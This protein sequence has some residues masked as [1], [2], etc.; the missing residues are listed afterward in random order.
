MRTKRKTA[1]GRAVSWIA[2]G[3]AVLTVFGAFA[4]LIPRRD[5]AEP[6]FPT[7]GSEAVVV[8]LGDDLIAPGEVITAASY[9]RNRHVIAVDREGTTEFREII[10]GLPLWYANPIVHQ[11][12]NEALTGVVDDVVYYDGKCFFG[13]T[14]WNG[15]E[16]GR[17]YVYDQNGFSLTGGNFNC[18]LWTRSEEFG[19]TDSGDLTCLAK[20][21]FTVA[22]VDEAGYLWQRNSVF[23]STGFYLVG[24]PFEGDRVYDLEMCGSTYLALGSDAEGTVL[25]TATSLFGPWAKQRLDGITANSFATSDKACFIACDDGKIAYSED[26]K[27]WK[28]SRMPDDVDF[29]EFFYFQGTYYAIGSNAT[30]GVLYESST[31]A[32]WERVVSVNEPL[33]A[34]SVGSFE[35]LLYGEDGGFYRLT[36]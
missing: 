20:L 5:T 14:S 13:L 6:E 10:G 31:G 28:V 19:L 3:L 7:F 22:V 12:G 2:V 33:T 30:E 11:T 23:G 21:G 29:S 1:V 26:F 25:Y 36:K 17:V 27:S 34:V 4:A 24:R 16:G 32:A 8:K 35:A 15:G 18:C 9:E